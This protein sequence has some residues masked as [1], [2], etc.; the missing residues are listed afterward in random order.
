M[1]T[2]RNANPLKGTSDEHYTPS[3][4]FQAL[5]LM[6]DLDVAAP[7]GGATLRLYTI[8]TKNQMVS[9]V[10]GGVMCG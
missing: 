2:S 6:F 1:N 9:R 3:N 7:V 4:I 5:N 10:N 8:T